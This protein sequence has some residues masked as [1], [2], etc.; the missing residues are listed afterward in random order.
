MSRF[1]LINSKEDTSLFKNKFEWSK[2]SLIA[3]ATVLLW[4]KTNIAYMTSFDIKIENSIQQ[5]I[6]IINP[7]SSL[8]FILGISMFL[9]EKNQKRYVLISSLT[10]SIVLYANV[11][12]YRVYTDFLTLPLLFQTSNMSDL[13][14]S[15]RELVHL[16]D[17]LFFVDIILLALIMKKKPAFLKIP[18]YTRMQQSIF[19]LFTISLAFFNLSLAETQRTQLLTRTFDRELLVKNIGTYNYQLYDVFL[20][21]KT[22]AQRAFAD[23]SELTDM[24]NYNQANYTEPNKDMFGI[25]KGKNVIMVSL[26]STQAFTVNREVDGEEITP[27]LNDFI[28]ESFYFDNFYHQTGQGKTSDS[29]FI[30]ENS[31]YPLSRGAVFFTHSG[32][33]FQASPE[34]LK[35]N[36]YFTASLHANNKSFWNRD[37]M[38]QSLGYDRF[39][40]INDYEVNEDN[41]VG[42]GLKDI[43][44]FEQSI[45]HLKEMPEP[46]YS[47]FITLTNHFPFELEEEDKLIEPLT[48]GSRTLNNFIPTVRYQDEA[49]KIFIE[50]LK[51]E[52]LYENS[53]IILYGDHNGISENH[54]KAMAELLGEEVTP[55]VSTQLQRVP[56][57]IH[58]PGMK[59]KTLSTVSGQM[60]IKPTLLHLLGIETKNDIQFGSDLFSEK[61]NQ[62]VVL[63]DGSFITEEYVYTKEV[64]YERATGEVAD[65]NACE[66]YIEQAN[67]ELQYSDS[68]IY[69]DLLR[70]YDKENGMLDVR[71]DTN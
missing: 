38:Y 57:V 13:G 9:S 71:E 40:E 10:L 19:Y 42:W 23:G 12:F 63:R 8:L 26:E 59:G 36:G 29:E 17:I 46:F 21:T 1:C 32:N 3:V 44:F 52:G 24:V 55:F 69:G 11:V 56:F 37:I 25:A 4:I 58:I 53:I 31:L 15:V 5:F 54:N 33:E 50:R 43:D 34:I 30:V 7:L 62:F 70:F 64:C 27:F 18:K 66:P 51:E 41:S 67:L 28:K 45:A 6:L 49:L 61:N 35:E 2:L 65:G 20:Q 47:K 16:T 39:Y 14:S 48:T 68:I 22:T 60:D